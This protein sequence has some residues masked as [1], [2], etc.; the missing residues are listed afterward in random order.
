[1]DPGDLVPALV[2]AMKAA[3]VLDEESALVKASMP[4]EDTVLEG[5]LVLFGQ[6]WCHSWSWSHSFQKGFHRIL[7]IRPHK[8]LL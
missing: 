7:F 2:L 1:M 4:K 6:C 3:L 8:Q 5:L